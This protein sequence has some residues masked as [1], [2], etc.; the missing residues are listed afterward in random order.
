FT[1]YF[2]ASPVNNLVDAK[3]CDTKAHAAFFHAMLDHGIYLPPSQFEVGFVSAAHTD[4]DIDQFLQ[5]A[6]PALRRG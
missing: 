6:T 4:A 5:S 1:P 3:R 2:C